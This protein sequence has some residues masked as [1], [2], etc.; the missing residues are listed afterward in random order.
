MIS[1]GVA[2]KS[3]IMTV[4]D[5]FGLVFVTAIFILLIVGM[6]LIIQS[7]F[8]WFHREKRWRERQDPFNDQ[9]P[10]SE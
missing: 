4:A 7:R 2:L 9:P 10:D 3:E 6:V 5:I 1:V 8:N